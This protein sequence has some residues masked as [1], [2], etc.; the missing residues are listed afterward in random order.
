[1]KKP[2]KKRPA[3]IISGI[4][5]IVIILGVGIYVSVRNTPPPITETQ[6]QNAT[7]SEFG[8]TFTLENGQATIIGYS[9]NPAPTATARCHA[10][11][12]TS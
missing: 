11:A 12:W 6:L 7:Y 10:C 2:I 3:Y 9:G 5:A 8:D 4:I 1:M